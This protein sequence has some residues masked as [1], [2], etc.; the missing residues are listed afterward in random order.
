LAVCGAATAPLAQLRPVNAAPLPMS[1]AATAER[2]WLDNFG[3]AIEAGL[4]NKSVGYAAVAMLPSGAFVTRAGGAARRA[5]DPYPRPMS[6]DD[7]I[8]IA[9]V[10]K[11]MTATA[12]MKLLARNRLTV[13]TPI[14]GYLPSTWTLGPGIKSLTF[15]ELLS[16]RSGIRCTEGVNYL[17]VKACF[18]AGIDESLKAEY[19]YNNTNFAVFRIILPRLDG[20]AP[21]LVRDLEARER[22]GD[23]MPIAA[24]LAVHYAAYVNAN[25]FAPA[26]LPVMHCRYTDAVPALSYKSVNPEQP[27]NFSVVGPGETWGDMSLACGSAGWFFSAR[28]LAIFTHALTHTAKILPPETVAQMK[29]EQLGL[30]PRDHGGGLTS[31][32]HGGFHPAER[33]RGELH[34]MIADFSNGLSIGLVVN[35]KF[36]GN[37]PAEVVRAIREADA[38]KAGS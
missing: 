27:L 24:M 20:M 31:V 19:K 6:V 4:G 38:P 8:T 33:N 15:R 7:K 23:P 30:H 10:S 9:S 5:P 26:G 2:A 37:I 29:A 17:A 16:H 1:P 25:V 12:I 28:Q 21:A 35:S 14:A 11:T 32:S 36:A 13:D 3:R 18:A 22:R 34:T